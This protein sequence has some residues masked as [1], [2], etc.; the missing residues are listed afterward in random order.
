MKHHLLIAGTGRAGTSFLVQYLHGC[1]LETHLTHHPN[2]KLYGE[3]NAGL[4]DLPIDG[5]P[6]PYV[7]KTPWLFEFVERF[8]GREDIAIDVAV[9]PMRDLVEVASSRVT[10]ELQERYASLKN[11]DVLEECTQ[12]ET[13]GKTKGGVVYSLNPIDQAR[14]LATG[15]HQ[16]IHALAKRAVPMVFLDFSRMIEDG[17]Y[18]YAQLKPYLGESIDRD[19]A[20]ALHR[21]LAAPALMRTGAELGRAA[22]PDVSAHSSAGAHTGSPS[23]ETLDRAAL[24]RELKAVRRLR[25]PLHKRLFR[26]RKRKS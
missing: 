15:F 14:I 13:W 20:L 26:G 3:A 5:R 9:L 24:L 8:L 21:S 1:G 23:F 11:P 6:L 22:A 19:A 2:A 12:W 4:E 16:V 18:L 10:L 7:V 17:D 25:L